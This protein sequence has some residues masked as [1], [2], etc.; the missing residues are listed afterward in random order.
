MKP[1]SILTRLTIVFVIA[2]LAACSQAAAPAAYSR[3]SAASVA[4]AAS[5]GAPKAPVLT[6]SGKI[7]ARNT[8][9]GLALDVAGLET[10][11]LVKYKVR[12]PWLEADLEFSGVLVTDLL[13]ATGA[14]AD[15]TSLQI[16]A[17]DDYQVDISI[18]DAKR[19]PIMLAT[20]T[21]G[22]PMTI[23]DKGPMRIVFPADP[24]IDA[25]KTKD[26]WI[27]QIKTIEVR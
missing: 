27:W 2:G 20:R 24:S 14:A 4:S 18:A 19:W 21:G 22:A 5:I 9:D 3:I 26:L 11:G 8:P 6:I 1:S 23:E 12:D 13:T 10:L 7:S 16:T 17:L 25:L 15:A